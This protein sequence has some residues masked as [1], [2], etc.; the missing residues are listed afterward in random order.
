M[1]KTITD[2][3]D[4]STDRKNANKGTERGR[5]ML[6][7]SMERLGAGRSIVVDKNGVAVAGN[8]ALE[9]AAEMGMPIEVVRSD[10]RKL[11]V[12]QRTDWDLEQDAAAR[13]YATADNRVG[14]VNLEF[15]PVRIQDALADG[16][17]LTYLFNESELAKILKEATPGDDD[18]KRG[19]GGL[20]APVIQ[21]HV[22]FDTEDQQNRFYAFLKV[23]KGKY[24]GETTADRLD[25]FIQDFLAEQATA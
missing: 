19:G 23:L 10:G 22:V 16:V 21:Y 3:R 11:V 24:H 4:L 14:Q 7:K 9:V 6:E 13:E 25:Q 15:E 2:I 1:A 5:S 12:V 18:G 17:D 8:H 20:G